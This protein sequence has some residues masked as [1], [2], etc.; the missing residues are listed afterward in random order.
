MHRHTIKITGTVVGL[1]LRLFFFFCLGYNLLPAQTRVFKPHLY[2]YLGTDESLTASATVGDLDG[3]G[4]LDILIGNGRHWAEQNYIFYNTGRGFFRRAVRL[5]EELNTTYV[6]PIADLDNDGDL[7]VVVGNDRI[8][9]MVFKNDGKGHM[10]FDH[11]FGYSESNTRGLCLADLNSDNF[12]DIAVANRRSQNFIYLNNRKGEFSSSQPFGLADEA[13]IA[14]ASADMNRDGH[15][16]LILANRNAQPN[17]IYFGPKFINHGT[18]GTGKDETR[19][20]AISDMNGDGHMDIVTAILDRRMLSI[21]A[22]R[23][24]NF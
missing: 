17:K 24:E 16:D 4:D 7:D 19:D 9:N 20:L 13:T 2:G 22:I 10:V 18:Y 6:V 12:V 23:K 8:Q 14:I 5:G 15:Q 3:D 1:V 21:T 11:Y